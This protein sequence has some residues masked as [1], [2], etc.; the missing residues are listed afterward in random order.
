VNN[1]KQNIRAMIVGIIIIIV[2]I[3]IFLPLVMGLIIKNDVYNAI[4]ATS[5]LKNVAVKVDQ[6]HLGWFRSHAIVD[7][8]MPMPP[9]AKSLLSDNNAVLPETI[10]WK[11][12]LTIHHGPFSSI[13]ENQQHRKV[14]YGEGVINGNLYL[15]DPKPGLFNELKG[16]DTP[17]KVMV[18]F[19]AS[20]KQAVTFKHGPLAIED[21]K[22]NVQFQISKGTVE[23]ITNR[24]LNSAALNAHLNDVTISNEDKSEVNLSALIL[25]TNLKRNQEGLWIGTKSM[26]IP[27]I[28]WMK[29][30]QLMLTVA[31]VQFL[32]DIKEENK[33]LN[34]SN[35]LTIASITSAPQVGV[36]LNTFKFLLEF[37][38]LNYEPILV[39]KKTYQSGLYKNM[40]LKERQ[41][42]A[43]T[44]LY[45]GFLG[46]QVLF[47]LSFNGPFGF[48]HTYGQV[49]LPTK[50]I[51]KKATINSFVNWLPNMVGKSTVLLPSDASE[52]LTRDQVP[53]G[54]GPVIP[55]GSKLAN[56]ENQSMMAGEKSRVMMASM[57]EDLY[58]KGFLQKENGQYVSN[59]DYCNGKLSV[60]NK[61]VWPLPKKTSIKTQSA[62]KGQ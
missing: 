13:S 31:G 34:T 47:D 4:R 28:T 32:A 29:N 30:K 61:I 49:N 41:S 35:T 2:I 6:Y 36:E 18:R 22:D 7:I 26:N 40:P 33:K 21:R 60:N 23:I 55:P 59:I 17:T 19:M 24:Q 11:A 1:T 3:A 51:L 42:L 56:T 27:E 43:L 58:S 15:S 46:S 5:S 38:Q 45:Q 39:L 8:S 62:T 37:N 9:E 57:I 54:P 20:G 52:K 50:P 44:A 25:A 14:F 12:N 48:V 53:L 10:T 16:L